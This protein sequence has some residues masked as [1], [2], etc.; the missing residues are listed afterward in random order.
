MLERY[1]AYLRSVRGLSENTVRAYERDVR[2]YLDYLSQAGVEEAQVRDSTVR[3]FVTSLLDRG[4]KARSVNRVLSGVRGYCRFLQRL[5]PDQERRDPL[6][7]FRGMKTPSRLPS[8]LFE[9]E[10][11]E[12]LDATGGASGAETF[13]AIRDHAALEILYSTGCRVAELVGLDLADLDLKQGTA[14]VMGKG[15]KERYVFLGKAALQAIRDYL[16]RRAAHLGSRAVSDDARGALLLNRQGE[17]VTDRGIRYRVRRLVLSS[18]IRKHCSPHTFRHSMA[19]HVLD[20]GADIRV[21]QELL[22]HASISTTQIY[23]HVGLARLQSVYQLAHP[24]SRRSASG[25]AAADPAR[26]RRP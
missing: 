16:P 23:T 13:L 4:L 19:T 5:E 3:S 17:R 7:G 22:G 18:R 11:G 1:L 20:R 25:A 2:T 24:H 12:L 26:E 10:M 14:R 6:D 9:E 15:R 8:F 21:V